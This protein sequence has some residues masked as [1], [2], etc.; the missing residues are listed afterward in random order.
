M[1][2]YSI[3]R[4]L[5]VTVLLVELLSAACVTGVALI[6]E[7]HAHFRSFDVMLRGRA[8]SIFGAV[9]DAEDPDDN[10]MLDKGDFVIPREDV[11]EV[12]DEKGRLLG[13][14][15]NWAGASAG[16][17]AAK[18]DQPVRLT[19]NGKHY[20]GTVLHGL[21]MIDPGDKAGG[22]LRHV[23]VLYASPTRRVW[24]AVMGAVRFYA[25]A[26]L[27]L[28]AVTGVA[29]A[30]LLHR[31]LAPLR[32][33]A[34]EAAGVSVNSWR[35]ETPENV[36]ATAELAPLAQAIENALRRLEESFSQQRQFTGDAAHELKTAVAVVKSSLQLLSMKPRDVEQYRAGLETCLAD[37]ERMEEIVRKM[38]MLARFDQIG[39]PAEGTGASA[40]LGQCIRQVEE[41]F[42]TVAELR[43]VGVSL[44][45]YEPL[46]VALPSDEAALLVS[47]LLLNSLQHSGKGSRVTVSGS[48]EEDR[49]E[50]IVRD[51]GEGID[52]AALPHVFERFY[53][54]DPSRNRSTGGTGLGLSISKAIVEAAKGDIHLTSEVGVGT[55]VTVRLPPGQPGPAA[56]AGEFASSATHPSA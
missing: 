6:Y 15:Q 52:P 19:V 12:R 43:G 44:R 29:M 47:N 11:Y 36:K 50:M 7:R 48:R 56:Q 4:R 25:L 34:A 28:M 41:Q 1:K 39:V 16:L 22:I 10:V 37:C 5:I 26:S 2:R 30:W 54:G 18:S 53:R 21:R 40:D 42:R 38:L 55:T 35:F 49:V 45:L 8:D 46:F 23:T 9:Q 27:L 32:A 33:L 17:L 3:A 14:S 13:R 20:R 51:E 24:N 31:G